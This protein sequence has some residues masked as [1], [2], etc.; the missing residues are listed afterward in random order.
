MIA[1]S[2]FKYGELNF[3]DPVLLLAKNTGLLQKII[4]YAGFMI[5][6][7]STKS[8]TIP[9]SNITFIFRIFIDRKEA[10]AAIKEI[11]ENLEFRVQERTEQL[12]NSQKFLQLV[13]DTIPLPVYFKNKQGY[14]EGSNKAYAA[15]LGITNGHLIGKTTDDIW[16]P[17][18]AEVLD[19]S[20]QELLS[21]VNTQRYETQLNTGNGDLRDVMVYKATYTENDQVPAGLVG[22]ILD[23]T[24]QKRFEKLQNALYLISEAA[25]SSR[26][27]DALYTFVHGVVNQL[28]PAKISILPYMILKQKWCGI[29]IL[30]R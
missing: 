2:V 25:S 27:L 9:W 16:S 17:D 29:P 21:Q 24:E 18:Q 30:Y 5:L 28:I 26:D 11:N 4:K 22:V 7:I 20:D 19:L 13:I 15:L 1:I 3:V 8:T 12:S 6:L 10:E 23:I 14:Y